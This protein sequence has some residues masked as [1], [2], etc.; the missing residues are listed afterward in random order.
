MMMMMF[1]YGLGLTHIYINSTNINAYTDFG[2][3]HKTVSSVIEWNDTRL[4]RII[5]AIKFKGKTKSRNNIIDRNIHT[6]THN[7]YINS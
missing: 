4:D 1:G 6:H 2:V 3:T 7:P 5:S